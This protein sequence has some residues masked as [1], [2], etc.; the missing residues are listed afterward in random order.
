MIT[1]GPLRV[2]GQCPAQS[3]F[4]LVLST[5]GFAAGAIGYATYSRNLDFLDRK[6]PHT[7]NQCFVCIDEKAHGQVTHHLLLLQR[8]LTPPDIIT[9]HQ[10][11]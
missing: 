1:V 6:I 4:R 11:V 5:S 10:E 2:K 9:I 3:H 8:L 7:A